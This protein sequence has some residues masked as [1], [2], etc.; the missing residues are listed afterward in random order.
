MN[1]APSSDTAQRMPTISVVM[2]VYNGEP[3]LR[4]CLDSVR[5]QTF[6]DWECICVDDGSTDNSP[7]ILD[8]YAAKDRR[9]RIL[10]H[11]RSN[12]GAARNFGMM[13]A[14]GAYLAFLDSDD[15]FSPWMFEILLVK[16]TETGADIV[17]CS[18]VRFP[19]GTPVPSF[20][21]PA[22]V[23]WTDFTPDADWTRNPLDVGCMPWNKI[24]KHKFVSENNLQFLEQTSTNDL[25][26]MALALSLSRSTVKTET[27]LVGYRQREASIQARKSKHPR[28]YFQAM[29][30]FH[31]GLVSRNRWNT[32]SEKGR[33]K[34]YLFLARTSVGELLGQTTRSGYRDFYA[35]IR[36]V[37]QCLGVASMIGTE[38]S[39]FPPAVRRFLSIAGGARKERLRAFVE[40]VFAPL[41]GNSRR[42]HGFRRKLAAR[43]QRALRRLFE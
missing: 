4:E 7:P 10:R 17:A 1:P 41:L 34:W 22:N 39:A 35:G 36:E 43:M 12:A 16:A 9:F 3:W 30:S 26:F 14:S 33:R 38:I 11:G 19:D 40:S 13:K 42:C 8:E 27:P 15:V 24:L 23:S 18:D 5:A 32:L 20:S 2:P 6:S 29:S 21:K 28:N 37:N 31:D 25:T